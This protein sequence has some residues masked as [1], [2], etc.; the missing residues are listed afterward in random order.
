MSL[1]TLGVGILL[2]V[3]NIGENLAVE[4]VNAYE[5]NF[6]YDVQLSLDDMDTNTVR[7][8]L[9]EEGVT[10]AYGCYVSGYYYGKNIELVDYNNVKL[11]SIEGVSGRFMLIT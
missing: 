8:L 7:S 11:A 4:V 2:M 3:N 10:D 9:Y 1:I 5:K 6:A